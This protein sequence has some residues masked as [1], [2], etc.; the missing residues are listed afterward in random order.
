M[1]QEIEDFLTRRNA[2]LKIIE[3]AIRRHSPLL[4][5]ETIRAM[6]RIVLLAW[7]DCRQAFEFLEVHDFIISLQ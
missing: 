2:C 6:A 1:T 3:S 4:S 5:D 7:Q